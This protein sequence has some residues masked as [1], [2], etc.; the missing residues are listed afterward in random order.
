[1]VIVMV[2]VM[3]NDDVI[4]KFCFFFCYSEWQCMD[5]C[6]W[7][8]GRQDLLRSRDLHLTAWGNREK[9]H[10]N[11]QKPR[12]GGLHKWG[13]PQIIRSCGPFSSHPAIG[14][15]PLKPPLYFH[16]YSRCRAIDQNVAVSLGHF[17]VVT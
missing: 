8:P 4:W 10:P 13:Y 11:C 3:A 12:D 7:V 6:G 17:L 14:D 16:R 2:I 5:M 15:A 9:G 1:M